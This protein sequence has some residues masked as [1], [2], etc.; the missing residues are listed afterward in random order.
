MSI[1]LK[2]F[3]MSID[4]IPL[5]FVSLF[6]LVLLFL[7][8]V[9]QFIG[10]TYKEFA[11][12][13]NVILIPLALIDLQLMLLGIAGDKY[14]YEIHLGFLTVL[15]IAGLKLVIQALDLFWWSTSF[16]KLTGEES[17]R[18]LR[19]LTT[20]ILVVFTIYGITNFVFGKSIGNL[21]IPTGIVAG[22]IGLSLQSMF[23][24]LFSSLAIA[25]EKP[26]QIGDWIEVKEGIIGK[27]V[28]ITWRTTRL[29]S[30]NNSIYVIPN[31]V[32]TSSIVHNFDLPEKK[33]ALWFQ[34]WIDC[35]INPE[36]VQRILVNACL[37]TPKVLQDPPPRIYISEVGRPMKYTVYIYFEDFN[38]QWGGK[39]SLMSE[40]QRRLAKHG[41]S[42]A[43]TE[44]HIAKSDMPQI[45]INEPGISEYLKGID[46]FKTLNIEDIHLLSE[47]SR[48]R[49]FEAGET[50]ISEGDHGDSLFALIS[51]SVVVIKNDGDFE[52]EVAQLRAGSEFGE[53]SLL[54]GEK[55]SATVKAITDT[56]VVE[57]SKDSM[58][59]LLKKKPRLS[60][61]FTKKMVQR[62]ASTQK[63]L[64]EAVHETQAEISKILNKIYSFFNLD[65]DSESTRDTN[66][67]RRLKPSDVA[68]RNTTKIYKNKEDREQED[69]NKN[70]ES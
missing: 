32:A 45:Q 65:G 42:P 48:L 58:S 3:G 16:V 4:N 33:Y 2:I 14:F 19:G 50:I 43:M 56:T 21:L 25:V 5:F 29:L 70:G 26:Y 49:V 62:K 39:T 1:F 47:G 13:G 44:M 41:I 23:S 37:E 31:S 12:L 69:E 59:P 17:P 6:F 11:W 8:V 10:K 36:F 52:I 60:T 63:T 35:K 34:V 67:T 64:D 68:K 51:G 20:A 18:L 40:I 7:L 57:V 15:W 24:N 22:I 61:E 53:M 66:V 28:D 27:V 30:W 54:T 9:V 46:I 38:A 55:R